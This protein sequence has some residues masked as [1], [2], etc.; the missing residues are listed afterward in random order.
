MV[1]DLHTHTNHSDG[2][3]TP[4]ELVLEAKKLNIII[5]LTDHNTVSGLP[6]FLGEAGSAGVTA[7]GGSELS[8]EYEGKEFHL[9]GLFIAPEHYEKIR[10]LCER[11]L[12]LKEES[13]IALVKR[14]AEE[15]YVMDYEEIRNR[16]VKGHANRAHIAAELVRRGY[17]GSVREAFDK[18]LDEK[19][20]YYI[21][22]KRLSLVDAI[23]F[24]R[25]IGA[26]PILAHPLKE[27]GEDRLRQI[28]PTLIDAGLMGIETMH[29]SYSEETIEIS[30]A[31]ARD[32]GLLE[33]GGSDFH[34]GNKPGVELA[35]GRGNLNIPEEYYYALLAKKKEICK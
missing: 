27:I 12:E 5:A 35:V 23:K 30:K 11:F 32:F 4:R 22:P 8:T 15:G 7:I 29:S 1:C 26:L 10:M 28:L 18:L 21:P 25:E 24:L 16:N 19:C 31:I 2:V 9:I 34:G 3:L 17:V 13:N 33:S 6:E 14:L 20:G